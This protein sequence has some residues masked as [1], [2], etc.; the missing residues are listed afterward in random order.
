MK[1]ATGITLLMCLLVVIFVGAFGVVWAVVASGNRGNGELSVKIDGIIQAKG[2]GGRAII[3]VAGAVLIALA[4]SNLR[5][6][7][8][9]ASRRADVKKRK[10]IEQVKHDIVT[11]ER[12]IAEK[13]AF[14][15]YGPGVVTPEFYY[16]LMAGRLKEQISELQE[17]ERHTTSR[18]D[19]FREMISLDAW[20]G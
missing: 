19:V 8:Q 13:K 7:Y 10:R 14:D 16:P 5:W 2:N 11:I 6:L 4:L 18:R 1:I 15:R 3:L 17:L 12:N 9:N 20:T